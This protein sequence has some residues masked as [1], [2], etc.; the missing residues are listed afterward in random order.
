MCSKRPYIAL[1]LV[2]VFS[3]NILGYG[4]FS[5]L[6]VTHKKGEFNRIISGD[7]KKEELCILKGS[8][9]KNAQWEHA[10]EFEWKGEMYDVVKKENKDGDVLY[11]CKK[12]T[13]ED[14][15]KKQSR[16]AAEK[17]T[18][19]KMNEMS[20]IFVQIPPIDHSE[21]LLNTTNNKLSAMQNDYSF[22]YS[23]LLTPP[24]KG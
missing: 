19:K 24:P 12:D 1:L 20:K 3:F 11:T 6:I 9:I 15:L 21:F 7:F 14:H 4:L 13:K 18:T 22:A 8:A 17:S 10:R 16:K 5:L 23:L 2:G